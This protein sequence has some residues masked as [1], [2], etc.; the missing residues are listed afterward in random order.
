MS[1][2]EDIQQDPPDPPIDER[3]DY[4]NDPG[5]EEITQ[6]V[7]PVPAA[8]SYDASSMTCSWTLLDKDEEDGKKA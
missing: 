2:I 8:D 7:D 5:K 4:G 3:D 1:G 6:P